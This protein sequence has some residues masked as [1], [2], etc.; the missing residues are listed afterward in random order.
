MDSK[1]YYEVR[2][3]LI[4]DDENGKQ[5]KVQERYLVEGVSCTDAEVI[6]NKEFEGNQGSF[7]L[8]EV[9]ESTIIDI[10]RP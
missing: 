2:V 9:K 4:F 7:E 1:K 8:K 3:N 5:K 6:V 10:L